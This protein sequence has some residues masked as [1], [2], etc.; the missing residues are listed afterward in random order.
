VLPS[1][2]RVSF[3]VLLA[4]AWYPRFYTG[5]YCVDVPRNL[6]FTKKKI[7]KIKERLMLETA[8]LLGSI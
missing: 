6:F 3:T 4:L 1:I 8:S 2:I 7:L 5:L